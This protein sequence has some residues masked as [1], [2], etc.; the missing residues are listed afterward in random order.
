MTGVR[1][2]AAGAAAVVLSLGLLAACSPL[3][4]LNALTPGSGV[5]KS[6]GIVY[7]PAGNRLDV[8]MPADHPDKAPVVVFFY[9]GTWNSGARGDYAFV[10]ESLAARGIVAVIADYRL[11]PAVRYPEFLVDCARAVAWAAHE[12]RSY[13]G[14]PQRLYVMG[15]SSGAYNAAMV[16]LDPRWLAKAGMTPD[17]LRGWIGLAGPY[18]FLP[19]QNPEARLVFGYPD[20]PP[21]SQPIR[22]VTSAAPPALL[23]ASR[24]DRLVNPVRN[25]HGMAEALREAGVPVEEIIYDRTSHATL[26]GAIAWPLRFLAP[27]L[28]DVTAFVKAPPPPH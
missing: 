16:A 15:H 4:A 8:Y 23:V 5:V 20:T 11:Y 2:F 3:T 21:D 26:V 9:G 24:H 10:G 14:D 17:V 25:T 19:I 28:D 12:I 1:A 22:H 7:G 18:D 6:A 13:G 27:V